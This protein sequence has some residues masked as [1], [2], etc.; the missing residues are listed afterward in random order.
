MPDGG[1]PT[2][3]I[4]NALLDNTWFF[5]SLPRLCHDSR[6]VSE[7]GHSRAGYL[8]AGSIVAL[9]LPNNGTLHGSTSTL[10]YALKVSY[11]AYYITT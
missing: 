9:L 1:F 2:I 3:F 5:R 8:A 6:Q 7:C 11:L 10:I 4:L